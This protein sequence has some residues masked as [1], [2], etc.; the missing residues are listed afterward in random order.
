M[1]D[2]TRYMQY[3]RLRVYYW[4]DAMHW[5]GRPAGR[6]TPHLVKRRVVRDYAK[7]FG[8][9]ILVETGTLFGDMLAAVARHFDELHSIELSPSLFEQAKLRFSRKKHVHLYNGDSATVLPQIVSALSGPALFWL[10]AHYSGGITA[11]GA[12][13][14]PI[15]EELRCI[16]GRDRHRHVVLIDDARCFD[17]GDKD[18]PSIDAVRALILQ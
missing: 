10:D 16:L 3:A 1:T 8:S 7:R 15:V 14:T 2:L 5:R 17:R 4:R 18:Y 9:R 12:I 11:R 6:A 13:D